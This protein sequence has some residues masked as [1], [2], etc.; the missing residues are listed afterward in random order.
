MKETEIQTNI[1]NSAKIADIAL[2]IG[3][4]LIVLTT[5]LLIFIV[6]FTSFIYGMEGPAGFSQWIVEEDL[7]STFG[8][9]IVVP[10]GVEAAAAFMQVSVVFLVS[11]I[12]SLVL[13]AGMIWSAATIFA[14]IR[15]TG[16]PFTQSN[17]RQLKKVAI[18]M[19][20]LA[21]VP[22][23]IESVG[24]IV[25]HIP[26]NTAYFSIEMLLAAAIVYGIAHVFEYGTLLQQQ[27]DE[28]F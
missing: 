5:L 2:K 22:S 21:F 10:A 24:C 19:G 11:A 9:G 23:V 6:V 25:I 3:K 13:L 14:E 1:Q 15:K 18:F 12:A 27:A 28:T 26:L 7:M 8:P 4:I 16:L 20:L 17:G